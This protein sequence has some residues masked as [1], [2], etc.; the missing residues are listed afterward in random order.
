MSQRRKCAR[1]HPHVTI[2]YNDDPREGDACRDITVIR[3]TGGHIL[4]S[5]AL[6]REPEARVTDSTDPWTD[7]FFDKNSKPFVVDSLPD[8]LQDFDTPD[9]QLDSNEEIKDPPKV[10]PLLFIAHLLTKALK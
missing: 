3:S 5:T 7:G 6:V 4:H 10:L 2:F 8:E 9:S 1:T